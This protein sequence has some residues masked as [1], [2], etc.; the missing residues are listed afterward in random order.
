VSDDTSG[1]VEWAVQIFVGL[2]SLFLLLVL[3]LWAI[4]LLILKPRRALRGRGASVHHQLAKALPAEPLAD[5]RAALRD[6]IGGME[7]V[8]AALEPRLRERAREVTGRDCGEQ[9][10]SARSLAKDLFDRWAAA[11]G[12]VP[13]LRRELPAGSWTFPFPPQKFV[14]EWN[15]STWLHTHEHPKLRL[16]DVAAGPFLTGP[17]FVDWQLDVWARELDR[18]VSLNC[19]DIGCIP[20]FF[21]LP[22][23]AGLEKLLPVWAAVAVA[24]LAVVPFML[25]W[26]WVRRRGYVTYGDD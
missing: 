18:E 6:Q 21:V 15:D 17:E 11:G 25:G 10:A 26:R 16:E 2:F 3:V 5:P 1:F 12:R 19:C 13:V 8:V 20:F 24:V 7:E 14:E 23:S 9:R 22:L 4:E